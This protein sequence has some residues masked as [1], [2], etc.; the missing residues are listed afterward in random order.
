MKKHTI[1]I[2]VLFTTL[3]LLISIPVMN[4]ANAQDESNKAIS[5][6]EDVTVTPAPDIEEVLPV[7]GTF[8][9]L[10]RL[11]SNS[12]SSN[13]YYSDNFVSIQ[14]SAAMNGVS[15]SEA[16]SVRAA[17]ATDSSA[18]YSGDYS[19][20]NIQVEGVDE[21]DIVK[22]DG[23]YIYQ[24][25]NRRI[26]IASAYPSSDMKITATL[27]F[28]DKNFYPR[29]IY[30]D[31][32]YLTVIGTTHS[33]VKYD[34][35]QDSR[36]DKRIMPYYYG[37]SMVRAIVYDI[38]DKNNIKEVRQAEIEGD[39]LSSR[40]IGSRL[41]IVSN[42][43]IDFYLLEQGIEYITPSY[44]DTAVSPETKII[45]YDEIR[46]FPDIE[47]SNY[48]IVG[49]M[50]IADNEEI[51]VE[52]YLGAGQ[53]IYVSNE[54]LYAAVTKYEYEE[55]LINDAASN[56][57]MIYRPIYKQNTL[58]YKFA[59]NDR[60]VAF[61]SKGEVPGTIINQFS[62]DEHKGYFRIATTSNDVSNQG[63]SV[64]KNNIY[65]L[66][67]SMKPVG[68]IE[69]IAPGERIYSARFMGDRGYLVTFE[70]VDPL[71]VVDFKDPENPEILGALKIPGYSDYLHPYD[72]NHIIGFGKDTIVLP[73]KNE[74]GNTIS[75]TA[76][77]LG[78][79]IA[80][81][82]ITD[83]TN[84]KEKFSTM[85]GD[86]G[87]DSELLYNHKALLFSKEKNLLAFPVS[88]YELEKGQ[89]AVNK[90]YNHPEYG[91]FKFQGA[92]VYNIDLEK[93]FTLK[94][95]ITHMDDTAYKKAAMY[96]KD[97]MDYVQRILYINDTL[98]T[99]S[100][101]KIKASDMN[102]LTDKGEVI[103]PSEKNN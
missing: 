6:K 76:F 17:G 21:A 74:K 18:A 56:R 52:T 65:V 59:L 25:N 51:K 63:A 66:D 69:D 99:L 68:K 45:D 31:D 4:F 29:E 67:S 49:S 23:K 83:V 44:K 30:V 10:K 62:M 97:G 91:T 27:N 41:Y 19:A 46:Y 70:K 88:V 37:K 101:Q 16:E 80:I 96:Y 78:M 8:E 35:P 72:E 102:T 54:N 60:K 39:Y 22:T 89:D 26:V 7:V 50:D 1:A 85:I 90:K 14:K 92:Y 87:T 5:N 82:D 55:P 2:I 43:Y 61:T 34:I 103:I 93:G 77:Y 73:Q 32:N 81:F 24:V 58:V 15:T 33:D 79:K 47:S 42:K 11:V 20:T 13:I 38:S 100:Q 40:K 86:R 84:P 53:N 48:M 9:N 95:K 3:V 12:N 94:G 28:D 57:I 98:Y 75:E 64:S 36:I 71:F